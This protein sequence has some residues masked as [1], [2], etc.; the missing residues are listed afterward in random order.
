MKTI[1]QIFEEK[2]E[3]K[4]TDKAAD[5]AAVSAICKK[6]RALGK[7]LN[8]T[9]ACDGAANKN[10]YRI[11]IWSI[12]PAGGGHTPKDPE[13]KYRRDNPNAADAALAAAIDKLFGQLKKEFKGSTMKKVDDLDAGTDVLMVPKEAN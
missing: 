2:M 8:V 13:M 12:T 3:D 4:T 10:N 11:S 6:I 9:V 5:K 7:A 1:S